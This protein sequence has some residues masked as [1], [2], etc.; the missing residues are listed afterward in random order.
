[1]GESKMGKYNLE[2]LYNQVAEAIAT[3]DFERIWEGFKPLKFA[4][5]DDEKCYFDGGYVEKTVDYC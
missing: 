4:L 1:M 5:Y 3:L 2:E